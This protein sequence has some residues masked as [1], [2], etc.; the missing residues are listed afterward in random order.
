MKL[1]DLLDVLKGGISSLAHREQIEKFYSACTTVAMTLGVSWSSSPGLG[2]FEQ[3]MVI[4]AAI[5]SRIERSREVWSIARKIGRVIQPDPFPDLIG[6]N[7]TRRLFEEPE[8]SL[9]RS[10]QISLTAIAMSELSKNYDEGD[11][12]LNSVDS[13]IQIEHFQVSIDGLSPSGGDPLADIL[14]YQPNEEITKIRRA[15]DSLG[16]LDFNK[17]KPYILFTA[18]LIRDGIRS[19]TFICWSKMKDAIGY[20]VKKRD[21]FYLD[22][23]P[24]EVL[25]NETFEMMTRDALSDPLFA[26]T[27]S[28]YD[29]VMPSDVVVYRDENIER[30][31]LYSYTVQGIQDRAPCASD[32]FD[33][34][35][36]PIRLSQSQ[37]NSVRRLLSAEVSA[38]FISS[39]SFDQNGN[40]FAEPGNISPYPAISQVIYGDPGFGWILAGC[41][42]FRAQSQGASPERIRSM[43]YIGAQA[44]GFDAI[45]ITEFL[46]QNEFHIPSDINSIHES[47]EASISSFG[48]SQTILSIIDGTGVGMFAASDSDPWWVMRRNW[49]RSL[50]LQEF[51]ERISGV[52]S[53]VIAA[54]DPDNATIDPKG[55]AATLAANSIFSSKNRYVPGQIPGVGGPVVSLNLIDSSIGESTID[56]TTYEGI[57]RLMRLI[58]AI[59]DFYPGSIS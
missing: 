10:E 51:L 31:T 49:G 30:D 46:L 22:E 21:V 56:L 57:S 39:A 36:S 23:F 7:R 6:I 28:L 20:A 45:N 54:I 13:V 48:V 8:I 33:V 2:T 3:A 15:F 26:Q 29:W 34:Q 16:R 58:R 11:E 17:R 18:D 47:V 53:R 43:S 44:L 41:N 12:E 9:N 4:R 52:L 14:S 24:E 38:S 50:P 42:V 32:I 40:P 5:I 55:L 35:L 37:V 1:V 27:V 25:A 19:G 59:Y